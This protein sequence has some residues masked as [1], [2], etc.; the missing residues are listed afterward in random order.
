MVPT[1]RLER[2]WWCWRSPSIRFPT[3]ISPWADMSSF[4]VSSNQP[5]SFNPSD[6]TQMIQLIW[7]ETTATYISFV[8]MAMVMYDSSWVALHHEPVWRHKH[9]ESAVLLLCSEVW[10]LTSLYRTPLMKASAI[11]RS[12]LGTVPRECG[13]FIDRRYR[14]V[15]IQKRAGSTFW[16]AYFD[17]LEQVLDE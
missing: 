6:V 14:V 1:R 5:A 11:G 4:N 13:S 2:R 10:V 16:Y 3:S 7:A 17:F 12:Y 9:L 8:V 15:W